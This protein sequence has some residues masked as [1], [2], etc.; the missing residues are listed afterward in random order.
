MEEAAVFS[1]I[2]RKTREM[3]VAPELLEYVSREIE[4]DASIMKRIRKAREER[5]QTP[6]GQRNMSVRSPASEDPTSPADKG[7][8]PFQTLGSDRPIFGSGIVV[9]DSETSCLCPATISSRRRTIAQRFDAP[10][11][12]LIDGIMLTSGRA[13]ASMP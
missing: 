10:H 8:P 6:F 13:R 3:L 2:H 4:K 5:A 12:A 11:D 9:F 7:R 1:G